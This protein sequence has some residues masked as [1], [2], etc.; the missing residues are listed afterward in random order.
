MQ[1]ITILPLPRPLL[2]FMAL[3]PGPYKRFKYYQEIADRTYNDANLLIKDDGSVHYAY[4]SYKIKRSKDGYYRQSS[5]RQ[6]F[7]LS[8]KGKLHI[9]FGGTVH[10]LPHLC[11]VLKH[12]GKEWFP[13][14][15]NNI[16]TKGMLEKVLNGKITNPLDYV[17]AY[18]KAVRVSC[19][20]RILMDAVINHRLNG[21]QLY[22]AAQVAKD[23]N[24]YIEAYVNRNYDVFSENRFHH[25]AD[26]ERQAMILG[27]KIDYKWSSK[28]MQ[29]QHN[30]WTKRIMEME[31]D[32]IDDEPVEKI[33]PLQAL[34]PPGFTL[35]DTQKKVFTEGKI[36][37]HCVYTN[38]WPSIKS[39]YYAAVHVDLLEQSATLGLDLSSEKM[40]FNQMY[41]KYNQPVSAELKNYVQDWLK[42]ANAQYKHIVKDCLYESVYP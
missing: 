14:E 22:H 7:T 38:Y 17:K 28:R 13:G 33:Q 4:N 27:E 19:S 8:D 41:G 6:G 20:P 21:S 29:E 11:D 10:N 23:V 5:K 2:D 9:W 1:N 40:Q 34:M 42:E 18:T 12:L 16:L 39:G 15:F 31:L 24:H 35:L 30:L 37:G 3:E 26:L 32:H 36:M 25:Y